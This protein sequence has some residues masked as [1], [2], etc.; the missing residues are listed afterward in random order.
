MKFKFFLMTS[1]LLALAVINSGCS[2]IEDGQVGVKKSFGTIS[3][4]PTEPGL[5]F[6]IPVVRSIEHWNVKIQEIEE[7][8][9]V[10]SSEGL[11]VGLD[12][13]LLF[14]IKPLSAPT[15]RKQIGP[16]YR[17]ILVIPYLRNAVRD[18]VSGYEVKNIYSEKG[19]KEIAENI[20]KYLRGNLEKYGIVIEDVLLRDIQL[21]QRF[22]ESIEAKLA[23]E[24]VAEQKQFE[25]VQAEKD[26]EIEIARAKGSAQAQKIV[27]ATLSEQYLQ[28][29]WIKN[30]SQNQNVVYVATE[31]NMPLFK[32]VA[33]GAGKK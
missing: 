23:A 15:I 5:F 19:R 31:S 18:T 20:V 21:P 26:A 13:S 22:K 14:R 24:Q 16:N 27:R 17:D 4:E 30:L 3:D 28:Y 32:R 11:I 7:R 6:Q 9:S 2:I 25:L 12:T 29:L 1:T 33:A 8:A 10:P